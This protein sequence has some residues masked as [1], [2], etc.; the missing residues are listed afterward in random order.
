MIQ[1]GNTSSDRKRI[2]NKEMGVEGELQPRTLTIK[3]TNIRI[4]KNHCRPLFT[5]MIMQRK[6]CELA[7]ITCIL[8]SEEGEQTA[9]S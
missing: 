7:D 8:L 3:G 6:A 1:K 5:I 4:S 2:P 9:V